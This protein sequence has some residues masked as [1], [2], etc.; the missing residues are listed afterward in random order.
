MAFN[1]A[2]KSSCITKTRQTTQ[3]FK[4]IHSYRSVGYEFILLSYLSYVVFS[5]PFYHKVPRPNPFRATTSETLDCFFIHT[6]LFNSLILYFAKTIALPCSYVKGLY[7]CAKRIYKIT[8]YS[9]PNRVRE[10]W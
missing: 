9:R 2:V 8:H 1:L 3:P 7:Y 5:S 6:T 4:F 10:N